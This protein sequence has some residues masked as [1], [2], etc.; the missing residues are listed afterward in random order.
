M[1]RDAW[2]MDKKIR[3]LEHLTVSII[4]KNIALRYVTLRSSYGMAVVTDA[5]RRW[6]G[7]RWVPGGHPQHN[8]APMII[9]ASSGSDR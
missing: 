3:P 4:A 1:L 8:L 7:T 6:V 5:C 2:K 9:H